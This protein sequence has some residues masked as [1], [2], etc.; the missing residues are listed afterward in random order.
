MTVIAEKTKHGGDG[1]L[2]ANSETFM[3]G[4]VDAEY[5]SLYNERPDENGEKEAYVLPH[6]LPPRDLT[7]R[8]TIIQTTNV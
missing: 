7:L 3:I 2:F 5:I 4:D 1:L 6:Y 8:G